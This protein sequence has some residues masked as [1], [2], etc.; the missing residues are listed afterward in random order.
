MTMLA[1]ARLRLE[2]FADSHLAGLQRMNEDPE[3]MRYLGGR[4]ETPHETQAA[5]DRVK[6]LGRVGL[7]LVDSSNTRAAN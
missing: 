2:P 1:T 3:V 7:H 5:I 6:A 4:A